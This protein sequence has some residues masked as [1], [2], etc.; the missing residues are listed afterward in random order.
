MVGGGLILVQTFGFGLAADLSPEEWLSR[1]LIVWFAMLVLGV[2]GGFAA[3][4]ILLANTS[5]FGLIQIIQSAAVLTV[6]VNAAALWRQVDYD[7]ILQGTQGTLLQAALQETERALAQR[8]VARPAIDALIQRARSLAIITAA[9]RDHDHG[10]ALFLRDGRSDAVILPVAP[11]ARISVGACCFVAPLLNPV[12][13][14]QRF[15]VWR[16]ACARRGCSPRRRL[17]SSRSRSR[18]LPE[19]QGNGAARPR[20]GSGASG[21]PWASIRRR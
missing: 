20:P 6:V 1:M 7:R 18:L 19:Q 3:F 16:L 5:G 4:S 14:K 13:A 17:I 15:Y 12:A 21:R 2:A 8:G 9:A 10:L 11:P